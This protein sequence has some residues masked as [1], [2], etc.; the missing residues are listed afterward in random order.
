MLVIR[1]RSKSSQEEILKVLDPSFSRVEDPTRSDPIRR[2]GS[3]Q[4]RRRRD[5]K[6]A[7]PFIKE[8][9]LHSMHS[10]RTF[11]AVRS[12]LF[13]SQRTQWHS[14][15]K[16]ILSPFPKIFRMQ[17]SKA[18]Q[19]TLPSMGLVQSKPITTYFAEQSNLLAW[20]IPVSQGK[21]IVAIQTQCSQPPTWEY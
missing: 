8:K 19:G 11:Q 20:R 16:R 14:Y 7:V 9:G 3:D 17:T 21:Y 4:E 2:F 1:E 18:S 13:G 15:S 10:R 5:Y 12:I 6:S